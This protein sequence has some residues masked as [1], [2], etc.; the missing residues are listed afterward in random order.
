MA[1]LLCF[2]PVYRSIQL[3]Y[4]RLSPPIYSVYAQKQQIVTYEFPLNIFENYNRIQQS[5]FVVFSW[6]LYTLNFFF[7]TTKL[8][9]KL[10]NSCERFAL[11]VCKYFLHQTKNS[12]RPYRASVNLHFSTFEFL[13]KNTQGIQ[14][15][16]LK[17]ASI[18]VYFK[19]M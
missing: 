6:L 14:W 11:L 10:S 16:Y 4:K 7:P 18:H 17:F 9:Q 19:H 13:A 5:P 1:F 8:E 2:P 3:C 15:C 12:I